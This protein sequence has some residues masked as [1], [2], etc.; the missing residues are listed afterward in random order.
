RTLPTCARSTC[1]GAHAWSRKA[2]ARADPASTTSA[3]RS[4]TCTR[5]ACAI[6]TSSASSTPRSLYAKMAA[7]TPHL[8]PARLHHL[9]RDSPQPERLARFYGE[10]L[11]DRVAPLPDASW[12]VAG[13]GRQMVV[14]KGDAA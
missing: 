5:S 1:T 8:W 14:G 11:G 12:L 7:M 10:L 9:R 6:R 2:S 13:R 3:R 4:I